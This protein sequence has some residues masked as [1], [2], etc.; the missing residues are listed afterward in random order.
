MHGYI[1]AYNS[2]TGSM[3]V[4][5]QNIGGSGTL[6]SWSIGLSAP[7]L[8]D[9]LATVTG[10]GATTAI[11]L[12]ITNTTQSTSIST[13]ALIISG[14]LGI[15]KSVYVGE[16]LFAASKSF[17]IPHPTKEGKQLRYGSLEGPENGVYV[18]GTLTGNN[19]IELPEYW[20][21]LVDPNSITV[22]LT[23][24]G[25]HQNLYV[26][27]VENNKV[28]IGNGDLIKKKINC[29]FVVYAERVDI[30]KLIVES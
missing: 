12:S 21:K 30:P 25:Q 10:R 29:F 2:S 24:I 17:L 11:A 4:F 19:I 26:E 16:T 9:T 7:G 5:V 6:A 15:A 23:P 18:R 3:T 20:T 22:S 28:V 13:G 14:G 27:C 8:I 1:T